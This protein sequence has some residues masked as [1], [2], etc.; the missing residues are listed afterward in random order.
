MND[1]TMRLPEGMVSRLA[2]TNWGQQLLQYRDNDDHLFIAVRK[3]YL[4]AYLR[5][6]AVFK[7]IE[8][9]NGSV[10]AVFD[11]RFLLGKDEPSGD[12]YFDGQKVYGKTGGSIEHEE[13]PLN[14]VAWVNRVKNYGEKISDAKEDLSEKAFL[15]KRA[16]QPAV[17]NLEMALPGFPSISKRTGKEI[18]IAPRIDMVQLESTNGGVELVFRG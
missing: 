8:E 16:L 5:G 14:F 1:F 9:R 17:I 6:R 15:S 10:V 12:L 4:S 11:Q 18:L 3:N 13:S 2:E 7:R